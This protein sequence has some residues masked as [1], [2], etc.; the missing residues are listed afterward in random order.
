MFFAI[1]YIMNS[2]ELNLLSVHDV[3]F[4]FKFFMFKFNDLNKSVQFHDFY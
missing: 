2:A 3:M 4:F 1:P